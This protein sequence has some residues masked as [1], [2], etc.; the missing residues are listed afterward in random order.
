MKKSLLAISL[1]LSS[2]AHAAHWGYEGENGPEFW[3]KFSEDCQQGKNQSPINI[4]STVL[5]IM[6][7]INI[8]YL[9]DAVSAIDNGHTLQANVEGNNTL[10]VDDK[11]SRFLSFTSIRHLKTTS[12]EKSTR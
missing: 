9:G 7:E 6:D 2:A 10:L 11:S 4:Q 8:N 12:T 5:G 1:L 3:G